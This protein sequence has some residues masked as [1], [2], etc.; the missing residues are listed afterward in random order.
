[1]SNEIQEAEKSF[2]TK[3]KEMY[4]DDEGGQAMVEYVI[5]ITFM[6]FALAGVFGVF[7]KVMSNYYTDL[8]RILAFPIP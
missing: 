6:I 5:V 4:I 8:A 3:L 2:L 7:P 1:M